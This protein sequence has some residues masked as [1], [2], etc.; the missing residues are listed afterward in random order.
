MLV[1]ALWPGQYSSAAAAVAVGVPPPQSGQGRERRG[2]RR[3]SIGR[4]RLE[5]A[6]PFA[7]SE[8]GP[9]I[10]DC[11]E[12]ISSRL[13]KSEPLSERSVAGIGPCFHKT[14]SI[15]SISKILRSI[16]VRM[17]PDIIRVFH[18][19]SGGRG[20]IVPLHRAHFT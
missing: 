4:S 20:L 14:R 18:F 19:R 9:L 7:Y 8:T 12:G 11:R 13:I 3:S 5:H 2:G 6:Y 15:G 10:C 16:P 1:G 17:T